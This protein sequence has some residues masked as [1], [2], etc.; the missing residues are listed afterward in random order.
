MK[1]VLLEIGVE[2]LPARFVAPALAQ[3]SAK[4]QAA[5]KEERLPFTGVET[6]GTLRRLTLVIKGVAEKSESIEKTVLGPPARL[7]K[8]EKGAF[9]PQ[10]AGFARNCGLKPEQLTV[11]DSAKGPVL[12]AKTV[13]RGEAAI[14]VLSKILPGLITGLEFAKNMEWEPS[15]L[16]F[17]RPIRNLLALYGSR[18]IAFELAGV[19]SSS[20]ALGPSIGARPVPM[21]DGKAYVKKLRNLCIL[22]DVA[23][24]K[25]ALLR[26][27]EQTAAKAKAAVDLDPALIDETVFL[28]E[29]P[30]P[31]LGRFDRDFL[32]LP[33]ALLTTVLKKQL[34]FF[35]LLESNGV[36]AAHFIGVR[37]GASEGQKEVQDGFERVL[38]ARFNDARFFHQRDLSH[39]LEDNVEKLKK[40]AYQRGLGSMWDKTQRVS[41]L[42]T[43]LCGVLR[44]RGL[45]FEQEPVESIARLAYA[46][47]VSEV[48]KEFPEL[49][50]SMGGHYAQKE[51]LGDRVSKGLAEFYYPLAAKSPVPSLLEG[52]VTSL[53]AK[54]DTLAALFAAGLKPSGS[55]D[56]FALRR[57][58]TGAVRIILEKQLP[59]D[60]RECIA[61]AMSLVPPIEGMKLERGAVE[62]DLADF[63]WQ[64]AEAWLGELGY[65]ADEIKAVEEGGVDDMP[66]AFKRLAAVHALRSNAEFVQLSAAFKRA[67]NILKQAGNGSADKEIDGALISQDGESSL[68]QEMARIESS[69]R[70]QVGSDD[71]ENALR[72]LVTLKPFVDR[73]FDTVRV[74]D[75]EEKVKANRI[76]L[77]G[78]LVR[79]FK[80]VADISRIQSS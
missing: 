37:D 3:L 78:R 15:R 7:L 36:L 59:L 12:Q 69:I 60:L 58:A 32:Q 62:K 28:T 11:A 64:R 23:E 19:R 25:R 44:R 27:L 50:G 13:I 43:W 52:C 29:H 77:L 53:A 6:Y 65:P 54:L 1:D 9:T 41:Q 74:M 38:E 76:A 48:V 61:Q 46:D 47:L 18:V 42:S 71:F 30:T 14:M 68:Y 67:A 33:Q 2:H 70:A 24:R 31:V 57:A 66:R 55:E 8:D 51:G 75:A 4:A 45:Q 17:A 73:F 22:V 40:V 26:S 10:A 80:S 35:P 49:Q 63:L 5:L 79:L 34:K 21:G 72:E 16:R 20:K 39:K 56:P